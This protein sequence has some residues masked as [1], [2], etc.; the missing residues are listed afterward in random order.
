LKVKAKLEGYIPEA[1]CFIKEMLSKGIWF[2]K[3]LVNRILM[4]LSED[5]L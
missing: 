3:D 5:P 2:N 1:R 4:E